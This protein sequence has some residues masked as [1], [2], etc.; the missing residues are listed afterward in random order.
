M[1]GAPELWLLGSSGWSASAAAQLGLPYAAAHFINPVATRRSIEYYYENFQPSDYLDAPQALIAIGAICA[2]TDAEAQ[3][4]Y[5]S[6][7]L[8]RLLRDQGERGAIPSPEEAIARLGETPEAQAAG[9]GEWPRIVVGSPSRV[10]ELLSR[11]AEDIHLDELMLITVVHDHE[12][13]KRSYQLLAEA[14]HL[15][16]TASD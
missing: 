5:T 14:F 9:E 15:E 4:L 1:P 12:A 8:R 3:R 6:Q 11:I 10:H 2:D 7:R 13:R 16:S